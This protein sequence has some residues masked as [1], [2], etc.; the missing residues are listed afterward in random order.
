MLQNCNKTLMNGAKIQ[1]RKNFE[2]IL[3]FIKKIDIEFK[4]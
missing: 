4:K 1:L 2:V 3:Q